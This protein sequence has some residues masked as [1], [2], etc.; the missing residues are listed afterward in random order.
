LLFN[1]IIYKGNLS[2]DFKINMKFRNLFILYFITFTTSTLF[3]TAEEIVGLL[4]YFL[5]INNIN[6]ISINTKIN[7]Y[8]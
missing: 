4:F 2:K 5:N 6:D 3:I 8:K 7:Y 1:F